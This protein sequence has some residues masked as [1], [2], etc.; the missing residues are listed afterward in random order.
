[1]GFRLEALEA[2]LDSAAGSSA[3]GS[4]AAGGPED[5]GAGPTSVLANVPAAIAF[6]RGSLARLRGDPGRAAA[7]NR[8]ALAAL[9]EDERVLRSFVR[10]NQAAADWLD[11]R[12]GPAEDGLAAVLAERQAADAAFFP[13]FLPMRARYDLC[14]VLRARGDL[15]AALSAA[16]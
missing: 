9:G 10:W 4:S 3:A 11:G 8:Q 14:E 5:P 2:W 7:C 15:S 1:M 12:L 16:G 13:G 6:L